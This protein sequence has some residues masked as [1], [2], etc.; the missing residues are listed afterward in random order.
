MLV[1]SIFSLSHNFSYPFHAFMAF[2]NSLKN[3][4]ESQPLGIAKAD[5]VQHFSQML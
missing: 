1:T 2:I 4:K 5:I 3:I